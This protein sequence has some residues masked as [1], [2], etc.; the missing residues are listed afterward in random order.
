MIERKNPLRSR[1]ARID[2]GSPRLWA[3]VGAASFAGAAALILA[4]RP[5]PAGAMLAAGAAI[6]LIGASESASRTRG[7]A[8]AVA[9]VDGTADAVVLAALAWP[10]RLAPTRIGAAAISA[11]GLVFVG[12]YAHVRAGALGYRLAPPATGAPER[13]SVVAVG[14][15]VP[16]LLEASLWVVAGL[17]GVA[18]VRAGVSVWTH[19]R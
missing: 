5:K 12:A 6:A 18:A 13:A 11:V 10:L 3:A 2:A 9:V 8:Y 1:A 17:A 15:L 16:D 14:L 19:D 7:H 4:S